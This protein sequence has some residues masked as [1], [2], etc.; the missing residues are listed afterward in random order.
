M[1]ALD[2]GHQHHPDRDS[3]VDQHSAKVWLE[4]DQDDGE[5]SQRYRS[6]NPLSAGFLGPTQPSGQGKDEHHLSQLRRLELIAPDLK[7]RPGALH[8]N[9]DHQDG[10]QDPQGGQVD[11]G[12]Q[13]L[14][15]TVAKPGGYHHGGQAHG[16]HPGL[17]SE[18]EGLG[19]PDLGDRASG[20]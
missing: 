19:R 12:N 16:H 20:G 18:V 1:P 10:H 7:P 17:P 8:L 14:E 9:A 3:P 11:Q 5:P 4:D 2:A 13:A 6:E 15:S